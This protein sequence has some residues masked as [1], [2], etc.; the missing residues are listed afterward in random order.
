[1]SIGLD[2]TQSTMSGP[3][4]R[5][6]VVPA[7][8][9]KTILQYEV[10]RELG[11]GGMGRVLLARDTRLG[12]RVAIKM[13]GSVSPV[14]AERFL[15][16]ARTTAQLAH[17]NIVVI[18][19][20][21]EVDGVR[22]MV[23]EYLEGAQLTT[24]IREGGVP[25]TRAVELIAPVVRAL[26]RAHE[27]GIIHRDLKPDNVLVTTDGAI[28]VL[29]FGIAKALMTPDAGLTPMH[30][31]RDI[32]LTQDGA[33]LGTL[34]YM[35]PE[36]MRST[37]VDGRTDLWAVGV[38][39]H[40][41][42]AGQHPLTPCTAETL[43]NSAMAIDEPLPSVASVVP[44]LPEPLVRAID[45][46]LR[47]RVEERTPTARALLAELEPLLPGRPT[48]RLA[49]D[50]NPYLGLTA[51]QEAD[52]GR[53]FGRERDTAR[54]IARLR[55]QPLVA[56]AGPSG[57]GKSSF[58][59]AGVIPALKASGETWESFALR[60]GRD[61]IGALA[62]L[63]ASLTRTSSS[64]P[65]PSHVAFQEQLRAEPGA[66]G[67]LLRSRARD[68]DT[69][70][71]V[72]VDQLE[73]LYTLVS[74][75]DERARFVA[76]LAG[77]ADDPASPLRVIVSVRSDFLD[78][79]VASEGLLAELSRGLV[80]LAPP[81][82]DALREALVR[83]LELA[84]Y[85]FDSPEIVEDMLATLRTTPGALPLLQFV[86]ARLWEARD[87]HRRA[88]TAGAYAAMGGIT[89]ALAQHADEAL[90]A[91]PPEGQRLARTIVCRLV[92]PERTRAIVD[93]SDLVPLGAAGA[94]QRVIDH[95]VA[96]R[97]LVVQSRGDADGA[98]VE[99]VHET[100]TTGWPRLRR[101]LDE[102]NEES[103]FVAQLSTAA[104]QWDTRGRPTGLVW[105]GDAA[106]EARRWSKRLTDALPERERAYLDTVL[107][108]A[109][110]ATRRR[111]ILVA[112]TIAVLATLVAGAMGAVVVIRRA[113]AEAVEH[114]ERAQAEAD[115]A[116]QE[117]AAA[118]AARSDEA[119][120]RKREQDKDVLVEKGEQDLAA[121]YRQLQAE[122]RSA[123]EARTKADEARAKADELRTQA[124]RARDAAVKAQAAAESERRKA[125]AANAQ[126]RNVLR[127]KDAEIDKLKKMNRPF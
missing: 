42:V 105:T 76:C 111:Q 107:R 67:S 102:S 55:D 79:L 100:L 126:L 56:I 2:Q 1:V 25:A 35:S 99:L 52:A 72:L 45:G 103:A 5:S 109:T 49:A 41:L 127:E 120:A 116:T 19:E 70:I 114:A 58:V 84:G 31:L 119:A 74:D 61:P 54:V 23:L 51:F 75:A 26:V 48:T 86:A 104:R 78:R 117:S 30:A 9:I 47:K 46:C 73:E 39:L 83:P 90:D 124:D 85:R 98:A 43:F 10:I 37:P 89:G 87:R 95:L 93:V 38:I 7:L 88:I 71:V 91:L 3:P 21:N 29:D 92:T 13:L 101:W 27:A 118:R 53:F 12:R 28:K 96:A 44:E 11:R 33:I 59:R 66:L 65:S 6:A 8:P 63:L 81:H 32:N 40:Q 14:I 20:V 121:A 125:E 22:F 60:P 112:A 24:H 82:G 17:E 69:G 36:Q 108:H 15:T 122:K 18:H 57:V 16:E 97:L 113:K 50:E 68:R 110:R 115:R 4:R 80:F 34:P 77:V 106:E 123:D 94:A 62:T 64:G